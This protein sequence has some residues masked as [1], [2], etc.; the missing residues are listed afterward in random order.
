VDP[1][2]IE[3]VASKVAATSGD[4]RKVLELA[5]K[6]VEQCREKLGPDRLEAAFTWTNDVDAVTPDKPLVLLPHA[7]MAI[8]GA[9]TK[10]AELIDGL[11]L[12]P[13]AALCVATTLAR[14]LDDGSASMLTMGMLKKYTMEAGCEEIYNFEMDDFKGVVETLVDS[15]LL[16]LAACDK[17]RFATES[18]NNLANIPVRL[19]LQLEDVLS[20]LDKTLLQKDFYINL[21][22]RV[23]SQHRR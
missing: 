13:K 5:S 4:A 9:M 7:M 10:Y 20:A 14:A 22:N 17:K 18:L 12:L 23:K 15:G 8:R 2:L 3:F 6:A 21:V 16:K 1:K 11:S 19:E